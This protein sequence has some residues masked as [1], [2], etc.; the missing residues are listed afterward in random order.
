MNLTMELNNKGFTLIESI[1]TFAIL[2]IA[3]GMFILGFYNVSVIASEGS[4]IKTE[5]NDLY[6]KVI[7]VE[8][9]SDTGSYLNSMSFTFD[10]GKIAPFKCSILTEEKIIGSSTNQFKIRL[11]KFVSS[12]RLDE[13]A[14]SETPSDEMID[15]TIRF[16]L[17]WPMSSNQA[18]FPTNKRFDLNQASGQG[19]VAHHYYV[20]QNNSIKI[21]KSTSDSNYNESYVLNNLNGIPSLNEIRSS[22]ITPQNKNEEI[23]WY[24][25]QKQTDGSYDIIGF[26]IPYGNYKNRTILIDKDDRKLF[27]SEADKL[28]QGQLQSA[29]S[30]NNTPNGTAVS[31]RDGKSYNAN[32]IH[33]NHNNYRINIY[34]MNQ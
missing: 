33:N 20:E 19:S 29:F 15:A 11:S 27:D 31:I 25:I 23:I 18:D 21:R 24:Q 26:E 9:P 8:N 10:D 4:I 13:W 22:K 34:M 7:S 3:G 14:E 28:D 2:A 32:Q 6:N 30:Q 1:I 16:R 5:T 12:S 17:R